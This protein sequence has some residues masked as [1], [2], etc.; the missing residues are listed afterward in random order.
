VSL[1]SWPIPDLHFVIGYSCVWTTVDTR[2]YSE[3]STQTSM[4]SCNERD[5]I[6]VRD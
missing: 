1:D 2:D 6:I 3:L 5:T 4:F